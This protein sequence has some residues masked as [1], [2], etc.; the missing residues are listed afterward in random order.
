M[1]DS[2]APNPKDEDD[3]TE[4]IR[5]RASQP[6]GLRHRIP[7][8]TGYQWIKKSQITTQTSMS[9]VHCGIYAL[10]KQGMH[11][12]SNSRKALSSVFCSL[13]LRLI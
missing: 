5:L 10:Y 7:V 4:K 13:H 1:Q 2:G 6:F 9:F 12:Y 8:Y 11:Q 3:V